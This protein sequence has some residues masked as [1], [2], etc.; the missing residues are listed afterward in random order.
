MFC[1]LL[2][3]FLK[4][5]TFICEHLLFRPRSLYQKFN[6]TEKHFHE[7][8]LRTNPT[9]KQSSES[10]SEED[11]ENNEC[12]HPK[13]QNEKV[14]GPE[15]FPEQNKSC[16]G[17]VEKKDGSA[18]YIHK[19]QT[20]EEKKEKPTANCSCPIKFPFGLLCENPLTFS[21]VINRCKPVPKRH[22]IFF[23]TSFCIRISI[24]HSG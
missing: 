7:Y 13:A 4:C 22:F 15:Y 20:Y 3:D 17:K 21:G 14:L 2:P 10:C 24:R 12:H 18:I 1:T 16:A 23:R 19:W 6:F 11:N 8:G 9:A 5:P